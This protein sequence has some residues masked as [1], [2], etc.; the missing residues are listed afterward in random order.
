MDKLPFE[1]EMMTREEALAMLEEMEGKSPGEFEGLLAGGH[2]ARAVVV[3]LLRTIVRV[4]VLE[5][6]LAARSGG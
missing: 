5:E 1:G 3:G 2:T 6:K 4:S